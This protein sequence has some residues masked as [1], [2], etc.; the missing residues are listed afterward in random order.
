[1][2]QPVEGC[3]KEAY[4]TSRF[5]DDTYDGAEKKVGLEEGRGGIEFMC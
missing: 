5:R 1:M 2:S 3:V 4:L